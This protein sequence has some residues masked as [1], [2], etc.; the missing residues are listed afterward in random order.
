MGM[1]SRFF[2]VL[3]FMVLFSTLGFSDVVLEEDRQRA[4]EAQEQSLIFQRKLLD[5]TLQD[6]ERAD[7][8]R[9]KARIKV[10]SE[11]GDVVDG[12]VPQFNIDH[13]VVEGVTLFSARKINRL[14]KP[15]E[16]RLLN[17][18]DISLLIRSITSLYLDKGYITS[19]AYL[20]VQN[21][22]SGELKVSVLEGKVSRVEF[23]GSQSQNVA[24]WTAFPEMR[25]KILNIRRIEQGLDQLNRVGSRR[26]VMT[27][28]PDPEISG[29][30]VVQINSEVGN[31]YSIRFQ[32]DN[33]APTQVYPRQL[34]IGRDH[35]LKINDVWQLSLSQDAG[36]L[37]NQN[38][39]LGLNISFPLRWATISSSYSHFEY[40]NLIQGGSGNFSSS[41]ETRSTGLELDWILFRNQISKY[42]LTM[43]MTVKSTD[44]FIEDTRNDV[45][46]RTLAVASIGLD[47]EWR[48]SMGIWSL[49]AAFYQG[50][51]GFDATHDLEGLDNEAPRAQFQKE[52]ITISGYKPFKVWQIPMTYRLVSELQHSPHTLYGSER[53]AI[54]DE[55]TVRGFRGGVVQGDVGAY[56][57]QDLGIPISKIFASSN[58]RLNLGLDAGMARAR[59]G[60]DL[61]VIGSSV[62]VF[63]T[64]GALSLDLT[65]GMPISAS[66]QA[67]D[68]ESEFYFRGS[69]QVL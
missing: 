9:A 3:F 63:W 6:R 31:P 33:L 27:L 37:G 22:K 24:L 28:L 58:L 36:D 17:Q 14:K 46:S 67:G 66:E 34:I 23:S 53:L 45:G 42:A 52:K 69:F 32:Y 5:R 41:G 20:P 7:R 8:E 62:G 35:L 50:V 10:E 26:S 65:I 60:K 47:Q 54:G 59:G 61:S 4:T 38:K 15:Y 64:F 11:S 21:L 25:G 40:S 19:R 49:E 56:L 57:R 43:G 1:R 2:V 48:T 51:T 29:A 12:D 44:S 39:S 68:Y 30:T 16:H 13:I 18:N 55:F